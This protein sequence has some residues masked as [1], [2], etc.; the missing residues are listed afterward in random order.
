MRENRRVVLEGRN[1]S[2]PLYGSLITV[3]GFTDECSQSFSAPFSLTRNSLSPFNPWHVLFPFSLFLQQSC[4]PASK[5]QNDAVS[6][7]NELHV[8]GSFWCDPKELLQGQKQLENWLKAPGGTFNSLLAQLS[9]GQRVQ[10]TKSIGNKGGG[11]GG[12]P[13]SFER[14]KGQIVEEFKEIMF[15]SVKLKGIWG[16]HHLQYVRFYHLK[17]ERNQRTLWTYRRCW[18]PIFPVIFRPSG[19]NTWKLDML[20][21]VGSAAWAQLSCTSGNHL[22]CKGHVKYIVKYCCLLWAWAHPEP[23]CFKSTWL[24]VITWATRGSL[25]A[26]LMLFNKVLE[27][28]FREGFTYFNKAVPKSIQHIFQL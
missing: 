21:V 10:E 2:S 27:Q 14:L 4:N 17:I 13:H 25:E 20:S 7:W 5:K 19:W 6:V 9:T 26:S 24:Y 23:P 16:F 28:S 3:T 11:G 22:P 12:S 18:K 1:H 8:D 15:L